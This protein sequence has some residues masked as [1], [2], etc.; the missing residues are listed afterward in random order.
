MN[1]SIFMVVMLATFNDTVIADQLFTC[2]AV[3]L[4]FLLRMLETVPRNTP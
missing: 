1:L 4:Q 2:L 3:E